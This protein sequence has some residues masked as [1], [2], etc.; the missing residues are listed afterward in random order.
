MY[1]DCIG[2]FGCSPKFAYKVQSYTFLPRIA[3]KLLNL[4]Y[5]KSI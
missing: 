2:V 5:E 4:Q 3:I 1:F